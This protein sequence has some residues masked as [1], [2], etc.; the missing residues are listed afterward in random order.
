MSA[1]WTHLACPLRLTVPDICATLFKNVK[2][3]QLMDWLELRIHT[4]HENIENLTAALISAGITGLVINDPED[5]REF[6]A[7]KNTSWD[8]IDDELLKSATSGDAYVTVYLSGDAN[9]AQMKESIQYA[10]DRLT[11]LGIAYRT[12][13]GSIRDEDWANEWKKFFKPQPIGERLIIKPSWEEVPDPKGRVIVELD[14]ENSFGTGRHHTTQ[15]CLELIEKYVRD[16]DSIIDLGCGSGIIFISALLLGASRAVGVDISPDAAK[17]SRKNAGN[18]G[19]DDSRAEVCCGD[20]VADPELHKT[21]C[22][23]YDIVAANIVADV[24]LSM[25]EL[26]AET[27]RQGGTL[28]LSGIIDGRVDEVVGEIKRQ[29]FELIEQKH[30]DIWNAAVFRKI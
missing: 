9:G 29:G 1:E 26:F 6:A 20:A 5:V 27:A 11:S 7:E 13:S 16:G 24:L 21:V 19:I 3:R 10:L 18:N 8:Y 30:R 25:K 23:K 14:P 28:I 17:I 22:R 4:D 2:E 12:E 15:L